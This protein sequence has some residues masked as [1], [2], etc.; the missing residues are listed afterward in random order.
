M[1][2]HYKTLELTMAVLSPDAKEGEVQEIELVTK[3]SREADVSATIAVLVGGSIYQTLLKVELPQVPATLRL[4]RG[5][6]PVHIIGK[7][8]VDRDIDPDDDVEEEDLGEEHEEPVQLPAQK[9]DVKKRKNP[10]PSGKAANG[11]SKAKRTK[12][13]PKNGAEED[14][15]DEEM[16]EEEEVELDESD[17]DSE[18][19]VPPPRGKKPAKK[20]AAA[21]VETAAAKKQTPAAA[22]KAAVP[23]KKT[24]KGPNLLYTSTS[25]QYT[26]LATCSDLAT[27]KSL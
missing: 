9:I 19:E 15:E 5:D 25:T 8:F 27:G 26:S 7:E 12:V 11:T 16:E 6:G 22:K 20:G 10:E 14:D 1:E 13:D 3:D 17:E 4:K 23:A 18:E 24:K 21:A 2:G